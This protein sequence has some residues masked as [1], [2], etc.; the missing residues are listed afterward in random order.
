M[1]M[2]ITNSQSMHH[3]KTNSYQQSPT[4]VCISQVTIIP[5]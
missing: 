4:S 1:S 3:H 5:Y 2:S